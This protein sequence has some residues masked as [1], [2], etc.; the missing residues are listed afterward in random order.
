VVPTSHSIPLSKSA[1][2]ASAR[3]A[4]FAICEILMV[5]L[6]SIMTDPNVSVTASA[7]T[8]ASAAHF[9]RSA[10]SAH[11]FTKF[12]RKPDQSS[13][14][15]MEL[16]GLEGSYLMLAGSPVMMRSRPARPSRLVMSC[17]VS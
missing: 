12:Q 2:V 14:M 1:T 11:F 7:A 15:R 16:L 9:F 3:M 8:I 13:A 17:A 5:A 10:S 6:T 4:G